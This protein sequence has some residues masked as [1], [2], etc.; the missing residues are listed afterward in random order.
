MKNYGFTSCFLSSLFQTQ[1]GFEN[2]GRLQ[3]TTEHNEG[4][5]V[6]IWSLQTGFS[7]VNSGTGCFSDHPLRPQWGNS[8][9]LSKQ[10]LHTSG[11]Q[12]VLSCGSDACSV[13]L[14][15]VPMLPMP[16][17][18]FSNVGTG[19]WRL[20]DQVPSSLAS[21][22]LASPSASKPLKHYG[23]VMEWQDGSV[24]AATVCA[25]DSVSR[26]NSLEQRGSFSRGSKRELPEGHCP[27]C[28]P[29]PSLSPVL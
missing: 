22:P 3:T 23:V 12:V 1:G 28:L 15:L 29:Q 17:L 6:R 8:V 10:R 21:C 20:L 16:C 26:A 9:C 27:L 7:Q 13:G 5:A 19:D 14:F 11:T 25:G 2:H 24:G 18:K 4:A